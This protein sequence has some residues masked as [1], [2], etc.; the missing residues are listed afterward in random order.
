MNW[1]TILADNAA[2]AGV[3]L[4]I[5]FVSFNRL[6]RFLWPFALLIPL[7]PVLS[8]AY[9]GYPSGAYL[10]SY[11]PIALGAYLRLKVGSF[12]RPAT[13]PRNE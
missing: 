9:S 5:V 10:W 3:G 1:Q 7:V 8:V 13:S 11:L 12:P 4:L 2:P 6:L